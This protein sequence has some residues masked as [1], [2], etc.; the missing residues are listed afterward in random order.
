MPDI[1]TTTQR[2]RDFR[3]HTV[4]SASALS[5]PWTPEPYVYCDRLSLQAGGI[6]GATLSYHFGRLIQAGDVQTVE[7]AVKSLR[8]KFVRVTL[9]QGFDSEGEEVTDFVWYGFVVGEDQSRYGAHLKPDGDGI[10]RVLAGD[11]QVFSA[12]G[13]EWFLDRAQVTTSHIA[14][15]LTVKRA[16]PFNAATGDTRQSS[17]YARANRVNNPTSF[18]FASTLDEAA[19]WTGGQIVRY[20]LAHHSPKTNAGITWPCSFSLDVNA[21]LEWFTPTGR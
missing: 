15:G 1:T 5:G 6:D 14:G 21:P 4:E 8:R 2:S 18:L 12:V 9:D 20:V 7:H 11:V 17:L 10:E 3:M 19:L 16:L 13:I